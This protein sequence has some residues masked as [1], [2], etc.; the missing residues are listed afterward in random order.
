[1][2]KLILTIAVLLSYSASSYA[3]V[4][5]EKEVHSSEINNNNEMTEVYKSFCEQ[6]EGLFKDQESQEMACFLTELDAIVFNADS[7][8]EAIAAL[9]NFIKKHSLMK[10]VYM[11]EGREVKFLTVLG[12]MYGCL[13]V[14]LSEKQS[15][16]EFSEILWLEKRLNVIFSLLD[17]AVFN[18]SEIV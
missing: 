15:A 6:F 5:L 13:K 7:K 1:M 2:K 14:S 9:E 18:S 17:E 12:V 11:L 16:R 4:G 10:I 8:E 3:E